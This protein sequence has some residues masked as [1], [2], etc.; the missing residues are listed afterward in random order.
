MNP[1]DNQPDVQPIE[2]PS[3]LDLH[4]QPQKAFRISRRAGGAVIGVIAS[5]LLAFA[6]GGYRRGVNNENV[7]RQATL[8]K[9]VSPSHSSRNGVHHGDPGGKCTS[10]EV[11]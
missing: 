4:P 7:A 9:F 8:P 11:R 10:R 1:K 2:S 5:V 6:Y 3:G